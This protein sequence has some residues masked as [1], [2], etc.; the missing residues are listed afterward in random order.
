MAEYAFGRLLA[1]NRRAE[2]L[3]LPDGFNADLAAW[4]L[5]QARAAHAV[6]ILAASVPDFCPECRQHHSML[7][8]H[9]SRPQGWMCR[10]RVSAAQ[11]LLSS[12]TRVRRLDAPNTSQ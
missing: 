9:F 7:G 1:A 3:G 5:R 12:M 10:V 6:H 11:W 8:R 4:L 2:L